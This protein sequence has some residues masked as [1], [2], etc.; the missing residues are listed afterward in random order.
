MAAIGRRA[1][2]Q[3]TRIVKAA[4]SQ[5]ASETPARTAA[6]FRKRAAAGAWDTAT[7]ILKAVAC[8]V[9]SA[10]SVEPTPA[11]NPATGTSSGANRPA[12][13]THAANVHGPPAAATGP[14]SRLAE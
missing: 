2:R 10:G 13:A 5:V 4:T 6:I 1:R 8:F 9:R 3:T 11:S 14:P 7:V 12:R